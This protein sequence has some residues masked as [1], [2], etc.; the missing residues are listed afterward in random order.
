MF[1]LANAESGEKTVIAQIVEWIS[2]HVSPMASD[3]WE[4]FPGLAIPVPGIGN[5]GVMLI[6]ATIFLLF[7]FI[8][9]YKKDQKVPSGVTNLLE[10][11][12]VFV[13]DDIA[14]TNCGEKHGRAVAPFLCTVFFF[15]LTLNLMGLI[16]IF[17]TATGNMSVTLAMSV[18]TFL[19][20][21]VGSVIING[22]V[23]FAKAFMPHV[24]WPILILITPLEI[25]GVFIKTSALTIRL[26][27]NMFAGHIV[28]FS[29]IGL[30]IAFGVFSYPS[31]LLGVAI[32]GL[33]VGVAFIQAFV[34]TLLSAIFIGQL[35]HPEH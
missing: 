25:I 8:I 30:T 34:F 1:L 16:P 11:F 28:L 22:P 24:P 15:I 20:M 33:E 29:F 19:V 4:P 6:I 2:H 9:V 32:Y 21:V 5:H 18:I 12:I 10:V 26:F 31:I 27:A 7:L 13:R 14:I 17:T 23:G 35:W 3:V